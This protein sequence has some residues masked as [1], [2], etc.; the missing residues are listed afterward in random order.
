MKLVN[1]TRSSIGK[2][3]NGKRNYLF[4]SSVL[5]GNFPEERTKKACPIY[6]PTGIFGI[7]W[8]MENA[9]NDQGKMSDHI[10]K[11]NW[12]LLCLLSLKYFSQH[13]G[14]VSLSYVNHVKVCQLASK[15]PPP[16]NIQISLQSKAY[17][18]G[19]STTFERKKTF[20]IP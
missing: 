9:H 20:F 11:V 8:L 6:N 18:S 19:K 17:V 15:I 4:I 1:G 16:F 5:S 3:S 14:S 7:S 12:R 10:F 2:V 13:T